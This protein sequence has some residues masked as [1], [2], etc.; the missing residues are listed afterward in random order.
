MCFSDARSFAV[1]AA[2][3]LSTASANAE[4]L[5]VLGP[6]YR[7]AEPDLL[8]SIESKI[9]AKQQSGELATIERQAT[10]HARQTLEHP[11]PVSGIGKAA[12]GRTY[13]FDPSISVP[14]D[15]TDSNG[16]V[17]VTSGT[18]RCT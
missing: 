12:T 15:M 6:V 16:R 17:L 13:Y 4:D 2:L 10:E 14:A 1:I 9:R 3:V 18:P 11:Q 7:I 8:T 5:G